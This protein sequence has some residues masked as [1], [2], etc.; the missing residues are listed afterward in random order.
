M[1]NTK[2]V[3]CV[4]E[5]LPARFD[6]SAIAFS[7]ND[8]LILA[9]T[10]QEGLRDPNPS[11]L[12]FMDRNT[13]K[14]VKEIPVS[15]DETL[16]IDYRKKYNIFILLYFIY[17]TGVDPVRRRSNRTILPNS[18]LT[19]QFCFLGFVLTGQ[20]KNLGRLTVLVI[21]NTSVLQVNFAL[22]FGAWTI[23][24]SKLSY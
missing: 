9:G 3:F 10:A 7:P 2:Q 13:L 22:F 18:R 20:L 1:R 17:Y 19:E 12:V 14:P 4:A 23:L 5:N 21:A 15:F 6:G 24:F 8:K 16:P 11:R